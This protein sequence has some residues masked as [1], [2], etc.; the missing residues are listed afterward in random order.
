VDLSHPILQQAAWTFAA[1]TLF[2]HLSYRMRWSTRLGLRGLT[3]YIAFNT[4]LQ[5][6]IRQYLL[7]ALKRLQADRERVAADL[8][9][10]LGREPSE[11]EIDQAFRAEITSRT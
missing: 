9:E 1:N 11:E 6:H 7:P 2:P 4:L 8:R 3:L 10:T 5:F